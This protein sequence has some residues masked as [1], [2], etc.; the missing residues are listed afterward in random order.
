MDGLGTGSHQH[1]SFEHKRMKKLITFSLWGDD[2]KYRTGA[3]RNIE[4][5]PKF[6]P[7]WTL[8]FYVAK[9][10]CGKCNS[11]MAHE[12]TRWNYQDEF[13]ETD[14]QVELVLVDEPADWRGMF[15]RFRPASEDDV[16]VFISRDCDSR[17]SNREAAAVQEWL[18]GPKLVHSM[19]DHPYHFNPSQALMG[20]M[21][22]MKRHA[23]PQ[24]AKL[25]DEFC[26]QYPDAWQCDQDF[27]KQHVFPLVAHKVHATSDIHPGCHKFP[28]PRD[29]DNFIGAIIGPNE[30]KLHPEHHAMVK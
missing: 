18:D 3:L 7:G 13:V 16:D 28:I 6:Y 20:G 19:G 2:P 15:W 17:L 25:I 9:D 12:F 4:L 27:L 24:M 21:F 26:Q 8:R 1:V 30:E 11:G 22:G 29:G 10:D 5:A 23:F 14:T